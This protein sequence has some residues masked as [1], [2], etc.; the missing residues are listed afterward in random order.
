M[1]SAPFRPDD[2]RRFHFRA[3]RIHDAPLC[4]E[5]EYAIDDGPALVET[6]TYPDLRVPDQPQRRQALQR[7]AHLT[8]LVAGV[9][10]YKAAAPLDPV[11]HTRPIHAQTGHFLGQLYTEGLSEFAWVNQRINVLNHPWAD[12]LDIPP[13]APA[14][15]TRSGPHQIGP[16]VLVGG[17]KDSIVSI[18]LMRQAGVN[19][20][21]FSV[22]RAQPILDTVR[23][24]GLPHLVALRRLDPGLM[25]LNARG[26]L[27]G[28]VPVTA[29]VSCIATVAAVVAGSPGVVLSNERSASVGNLRWE[30]HEINH[31]WAKGYDCERALAGAIAR[32]VD[33]TLDYLSLLRPLSELAIARSFARHP[34]YHRHFISCNRPYSIT[35]QRD[36]AWCLDCPK[37]RFVYLALAPF[38]D[39]QALIEIFGRDLLDDPAQIAGV[40]ALTGA[41]GAKPFECVGEIEESRAALLT[42]AARPEWSGRVVV[43]ELAPQLG[44]PSSSAADLTPHLLP[45]GPHSVPEHLLEVVRSAVAL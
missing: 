45:A 5:L 1:S 34:Q 13:Q 32:E 21:L 44:G 27:N 24:A 39:R 38:L 30:G 10:Y 17:G 22:G 19:P 28:H 41:V 25:E 42:L 15:A 3:V 14:Q 36:A 6:I 31:Q 11:I 9:S 23:I 12:R 40:A 33:P 4:L 18:E 26:A 16:L 7:A 43:R 37:C 8:H 35:T 20:V 29:V 2:Q